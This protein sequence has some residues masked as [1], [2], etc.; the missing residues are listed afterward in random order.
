MSIVELGIEIN[1]KYDKLKAEIEAKELNEP[2]TQEDK[3]NEIAAIEAKELTD[4]YTQEDKDNELAIVNAKVITKGYTQADKDKELE[5]N[6]TLRN[7]ELTKAEQEYTNM[8][9][10]L[11]NNK[12]SINFDYINTVLENLDF[13]APDAYEADKYDYNTVMTQLANTEEHTKYIYLTFDNKY[14]ALD[15]L[16]ETEYNKYIDVY[17]YVVEKYDRLKAAIEAKEIVDEYTQEDKDNEIAAIEAKELTDTY[18]QEDKNNELAVVNAKELIDLYT[19]E[20]KDN[21]IAAIEAKELTDTYTQE[22]K[23]NELAEI[24]AKEVVKL[25]TQADK[26]KE[27][28]DNETARNNELKPIN[29]DYINIITQIGIAMTALKTDRETGISGD[30]HINGKLHV[31]E[32][33]N[34]EGKLNNISVSDILTQ[35]HLTTINTTLNNKADSSHT[36][37]L[38]DIED[39]TTPTAY[40]DTELRE[41]INTNTTNINNKAD[42][43]HTH[44]IS[45]ITDYKTYDDTEIKTNISSINTSLNNKADSNHKHIISDITDY[46]AYDD[47]EIKTNISS[48]NTMLNNKADSSHKHKLEDIE[49]YTT[50]TAYD[51]TEIRTLINT[52]TTNINNKADSNHTHTISDITDYKAYDDTEI[53]TNIS[54]INT[55]L[56]NKANSKHTHKLE[57]IE[58]STYIHIAVPTV[59]T[60]NN[61][62]QSNNAIIFGPLDK[63]LYFEGI[64]DFQR[65]SNP[66]IA[67]F[68]LEYN[69]L[70]KEMKI[71]NYHMIQSRVGGDG[72]SWSHSFP[73]VIRL[74]NNEQYLLFTQYG[75]QTWIHTLPTFD[76][77][78]NITTDNFI[79]VAQSQLSIPEEET[80]TVVITNYQDKLTELETNISSIN[81]TLSNKADSSHTHT[82]SDISD[83]KTKIVDLIY[84]AG[85][86]YNSVYNTDPATLFGGLWLQLGDGFNGDYY[87]WYRA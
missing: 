31:D 4:T 1:D 70:S 57:D 6:E 17:E 79:T 26:D 77:Y 13:P 46:K 11:K 19:Q 68:K 39:Y 60:I 85:S 5:N 24:E 10:A 78:G 53:K 36:H 82:I 35:E 84:P 81:T 56:N 65:T 61:K 27:L 52:N 62:G 71:L 74:Y 29:A 50:P 7:N 21:E 59:A 43:K 22:D 86:I 55:T 8:T 58:D 33:V 49:D 51:D 38:E 87:S 30:V 3:D 37:K 41:L 54:S 2:Y 75:C 63:P 80:I 69:N 14:K 20:D 76:G 64:Y 48:I 73:F 66:H 42:S 23:D 47:T 28:E 15:E 83:Y 34:L 45:D 67:S 25:Y 16:S 18:T 44:T 9:D 12:A 72:V 40:D 32:D